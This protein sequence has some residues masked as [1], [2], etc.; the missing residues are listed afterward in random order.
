MNSGILLTNGPVRVE[1]LDA[2]SNRLG[3]G[4]CGVVALEIVVGSVPG[5][6]SLF[7]YYTNT[8]RNWFGV[9]R[10][11][12]PIPPRARSVRFSVGFRRPTLQERFQM[13]FVK[14][15]TLVAPLAKKVARLLPSTER[16]LVHQAD[17]QLPPFPDV[18]EAHN[19][20][21]HTNRRPAPLFE[22]GGSNSLLDWLSE[23]VSRGGR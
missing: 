11:E 20:T 8:S 12:L 21:L 3:R 16:W 22:P 19:Q 17:V 2:N 15:K 18:N 10:P 14:D 1:M 4:T 7:S 23:P 13:A 6:G 9:E 5:G